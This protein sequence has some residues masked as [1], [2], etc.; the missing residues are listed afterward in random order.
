LKMNQILNLETRIESL[1]FTVR[2]TNA[3]YY[4][5]IKCISHLT[6]KTAEELLQGR[7]FGL[8]S[9]REVRKVLASCGFSLKGDILFDTEAE[10]RLVQD[11]PKTIKDIELVLRDLERK[12]RNIA[13]Q[14]DQL[15]CNMQPLDKQ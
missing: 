3:L 12:I 5:D 2:T 15:H 10:K 7:N 13:L 4:Q 9:L 8:Y 14:L 11:L 1:P 6:S